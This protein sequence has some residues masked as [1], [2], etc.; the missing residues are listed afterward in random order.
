MN[1]MDHVAFGLEYSLNPQHLL[2][3]FAVEAIMA[4]KRQTKK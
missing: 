4:E 3:K 2:N 1:L